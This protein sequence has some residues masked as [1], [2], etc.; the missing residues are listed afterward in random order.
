MLK[1]KFNKIFRSNPST[2]LGIGPMSK[3]ITIATTELSNMYNVD[4]M[5]IASRRQID[6]KSF[7]GGY[8]NN[9]DTRSFSNFINKLDKKK[10]IIL[11]RD[12]GGPW[13]NDSEIKSKLTLSQA[14]RSAKKS[15]KEDIDSNFEIIH[16]DP[17]I[18]PFNKS[19]TTQQILDRVFELYDFVMEY[20]KKKIK[21]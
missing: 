18:D 16:I 12:H 14:M 7:G 17:S 3:N 2:L 15:Y 4:L 5:L 13:Q 10:K 11:C 1:N 6:S 9:W 8:V 19:I 21:I 20:A